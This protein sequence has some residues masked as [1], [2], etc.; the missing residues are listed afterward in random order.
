MFR[1]DASAVIH[2]PEQAPEIADGGVPDRDAA[3][4][5]RE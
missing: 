4:E 1:A 2:S 5:K 3:V